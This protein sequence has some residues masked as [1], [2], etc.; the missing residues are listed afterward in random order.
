MGIESLGV[1]F[2]LNYI[3]PGLIVMRL[4][5][6]QNP[7]LRQTVNEQILSATIFGAICFLVTNCFPAAIEIP[8]HFKDR[9]EVK[10]LTIKLSESPSFFGMLIVPMLVA[11]GRKRVYR[12]VYPNRHP[13]SVAWEYVF[14][15]YLVGKAPIFLKVTLNDGRIVAGIMMREATASEFPDN[16]QIFL[17]YEYMVT[18]Q[19]E[20]GDIKPNSAGVLL[21]GHN[22]SHIEF[23]QP[24]AE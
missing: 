21:M 12:M 14:G 3:I 6:Y 20:I 9:E 23:I 15:D 5:S 2:L 24:E 17:D 1:D 8:L 18:T 4:W 7:N 13:S 16:H 11:W 19:G 10:V 22:I